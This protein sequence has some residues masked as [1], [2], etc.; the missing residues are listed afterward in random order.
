MGMTTGKDPSSLV[1]TSL[2]SFQGYGRIYH[3]KGLSAASGKSESTTRL[4]NAMQ[5][6]IV[7][8]YL[9][10]KGVLQAAQGRF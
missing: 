3:S 1:A 9:E 2:P 10:K 7:L 4:R 8:I 5:W 6:G